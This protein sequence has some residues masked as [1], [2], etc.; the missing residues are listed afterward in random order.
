MALLLAVALGSAPLASASAQEGVPPKLALLVMLKVLTYDKNFAAR[1]KGDF[2]VLIAHEP[3]RAAARDELLATASQ[4]RENAIQSRPLK[5]VSAPAGSAKELG[6][7]AQKLGAAAI[8]AVP[9][10]SAATA[11]IIAQ[12][13]KER[14]LYSLALDPPLAEKELVLG[15]VNKDGRPQIIIN[16]PAAKDINATF[17]PTVLRLARVIQ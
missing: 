1:G 6:E 5:F 13:A 8:V 17:E 15:V 14:S 4:L 9:G 7:A 16:L 2:I 3:S 11:G 10:T 12:V